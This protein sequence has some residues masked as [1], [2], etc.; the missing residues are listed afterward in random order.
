MTRILVADDHRDTADTMCEFLASH[1]YQAQTAYD[2]LSALEAIYSFDPAV[3]FLDLS[4]PRMTG[5]QVAV[6]LRSQ[7]SG[8]KIFLVAVSGDTGV[9]LSERVS[10]A[11]FNHV[12]AKPA[13]LAALLLL[14]ETAVRW[15][16]AMKVIANDRVGHENGRIEELMP[17]DGRCLPPDC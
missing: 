8:R 5:I 2:G 6:A 4:M 14:A 16:L 9:D 10:Q 11:G 17:F 3:V 12:F 1:G 15:R 13:D 7:L